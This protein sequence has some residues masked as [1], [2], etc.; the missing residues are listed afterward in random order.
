MSK[1]LIIE[2][3]PI[4]LESLS[5]FLEE[6]G[7]EVFQAENGKE[8]VDLATK[9]LPDLILCDI[10]MPKLNGY[11][12]FEKLKSEVST[13]LIPF[14]FLT[15]K[16]EREDILYGMTLGADDYITKPVDFD[17]LLVRISRRMEKTRET[18]RRSEI[19]YH[20]VFETVH[21][22]ILLI[23]LSDLAV[24]D[25]NQAACNLLELSREEIL[26]MSGRR[27]IQD[28]ILQDIIDEQQ[29]R[30]RE[31][32]DFHNIEATW[33]SKEG[34]DILI[35][36]RGK[37]ITLFSEKFLFM[38]AQDIT[39]RKNYE[40]QLILA[41]EKAEESDRLKSSILSN[42][43]H[44]LRTPLNGILGFSELLQD[45]LRNTEYLPM[46]ENIHISGRRLMSTL[47]SIITLSQLQAGK[48][49]M[50][51]KHI[52]LVAVMKDICKS[53]GEQAEEK[54]I[55]LQTDFPE[56]LVGFTDQ[57]LF[58][59]LFRQILDN[60]VKFTRQGGVTIRA[61]TVNLDNTLWQTIEIE[62]TGIGIEQEF[63]DIIFHEF[64]QASEGYNRK[65]QGTGLGLT[66]SRRIVELLKGKITMKST[67]GTGSSFTIWLPASHPQQP[68]TSKPEEPE[69][70][71]HLRP[72]KK[73]RDIPLV[74]LVE[75]NLINKNLI[76][77]FLKP[78][79]H[80]EHAFE[81]QTAVKMA[82]EK[83]YDAI[84]MDINL[85]SGMDG[86]EATKKIKAISGY[87]KVPIIAVTGYT[88]I[89]DRERLL[90][91]GCT[92]YIAKPFQKAELRAL[93]KEAIFGKE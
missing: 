65:F 88:M 33:K 84:L 61:S 63:F 45:D 34:N 21:D 87:E 26:A 41:K 51:F 11:E 73:K 48:V 35:Q 10:F 92:H 55:F 30:D 27:F 44:E 93:I 62:D 75:D 78:T 16:A 28:I 4:L 9:E 74:L 67:P 23:R 69:R 18:I 77:L 29:T 46:V 39:G 56:E 50:V 40:Q 52:N 5:D 58:R 53:F 76:E 54:K 17:E 66:I 47:N 42:I 22:A 82:S 85:G 13:S 71:L 43:S 70:V 19:K 6:E 83:T 60:A 59:Q 64:R 24:V 36:V 14:I 37:I 57:P 1:I 72:E 32:Q 38:M 3:D 7:M 25:A 81:G 2:D 15:A 86:I 31:I 90:A 89:G 20:A 80:M 49:T 8:G 91:E 12:A 79:Y 68:A